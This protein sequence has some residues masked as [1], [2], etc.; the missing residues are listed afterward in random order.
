MEV[1]AVAALSL[2]EGEDLR[3]GAEVPDHA[4]A[5]K[6]FPDL[7]ERCRGFVFVREAEAN[8]VKC[9]DLDRQRAAPRPTS[10]TE[11]RAVLH[12]GGGAVQM[13]RTECAGLGFRGVRGGT[14]FI[15]FCHIIIRP[16]T[17]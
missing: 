9:A 12:P 4:F 7:F 8:Q 17:P 1:D 10:V 14:A 11:A 5:L 6:S 13:D 3:L 16:L 2:F 15:Y